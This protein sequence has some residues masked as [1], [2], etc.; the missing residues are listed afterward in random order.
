MFA[1][2]FC[3]VKINLPGR[4]SVTVGNGWRS[5]CIFWRTCL[6]STSALMPLCPIIIIWFCMPISMRIKLLA[7]M[8][9]ACAGVNY[10]ERHYWSI[11]EKANIRQR[12][13]NNSYRFYLVHKS[14]IVLHRSVVYMFSLLHLLPEQKRLA[15]IQQ[16]TLSTN[17]SYALII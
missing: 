1:A 5:V 12:I 2:R 16:T 15:Y 6:I 11:R 13:V 8:K 9:C 10:T 7:M 14:G 17:S 3:A 4:V